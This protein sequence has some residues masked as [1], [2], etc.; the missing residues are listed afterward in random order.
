MLGQF[1]FQSRLPREPMGVT[2]QA[3]PAHFILGPQKPDFEVQKYVCLLSLQRRFLVYIRHGHLITVCSGNKTPTQQRW[4]KQRTAMQIQESWV[5][6]CCIVGVYHDI[7]MTHHNT[8]R[9]QLF[10][11]L[12]NKQQCPHSVILLFFKNSGIKGK[13]C[14]ESTENKESS[15]LHW[16]QRSVLSRHEKT[17]G[18]AQSFPS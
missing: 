18:L 14:T 7:P 13:R 16:Y 15:I 17:P 11:I 6:Y 8:N 10:L 5:S 1:C 2:V 3:D 12:S 9:L 4:E